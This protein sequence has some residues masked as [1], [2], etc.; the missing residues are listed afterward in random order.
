MQFNMVSKKYPVAWQTT[1]TI[2]KVQSYVVF[3][4]ILLLFLF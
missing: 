2:S 1:R 3:V 4:I